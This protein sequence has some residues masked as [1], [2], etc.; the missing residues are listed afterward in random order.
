MLINCSIIFFFFQVVEIDVWDGFDNDSR[1]YDYISNDLATLV[2]EKPFTF[3]TFVQPVC[4]DLSG[5]I[6]KPA[7]VEM[8]T[9]YVSNRKIF[10]FLWN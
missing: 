3:D 4:V 10:S 6:N 5:V 9:G 1:K 8:Q 7:H 2:I